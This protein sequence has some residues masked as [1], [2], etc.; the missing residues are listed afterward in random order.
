MYWYPLNA[1]VR[2]CGHGHEDAQDLTQES[3]ARLFAKA[4][5][6]RADPHKGRFRS[7]L[8]TG[9]KTMLSSITRHR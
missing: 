8:L 7:F 4:Y 9:I 2:R 6:A 5:L 3:F 1:Y